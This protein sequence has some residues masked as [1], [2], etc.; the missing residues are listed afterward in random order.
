MV[1]INK[2]RVF[3]SDCL[4][5]IFRVVRIDVE[6]FFDTQFRQDGVK[7]RIRYFLL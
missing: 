7:L 1:S 6:Q 5:K 2:A 3:S 4:F